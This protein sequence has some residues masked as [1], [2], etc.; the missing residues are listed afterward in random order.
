MESGLNSTQRKVLRG[1]AHELK[2]VV[3]IGKNG[4]TEAL[5]QSVSRAFD[6]H[7]LIKIRFLGF[8]DDKK[9][10]SHQIAGRLQGDVIGLIGN[11][12]ILYRQH[13]DP[14]KRKIKLQTNRAE[15]STKA[16]DE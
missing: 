5:I 1:L 9:E 8:K 16:D 10:F 7:E 13:A 14:E 4:L 2:P 12:A 15:A 11:I 6:E 3:Q